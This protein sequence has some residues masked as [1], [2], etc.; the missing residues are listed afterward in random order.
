MTLSGEMK[1]VRE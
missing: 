1:G